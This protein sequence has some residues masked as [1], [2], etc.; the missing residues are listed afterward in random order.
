M[1]RK[2]CVVT[3]TRAEY[4]LLRWVMHGIQD[5]DLLELQLI[6]TGMHLSPEFGLTVQNIEADGFRIDRK[7]EMLLS[8]DTPVGITKSIG[9]GLIGCADALAELQPDFLLVLGDRFEIFS[10]VAAALIARIPIAHIHGGELTEG[11]F[12][13]AI[14]HS[15][16]KMSH[17]HFVANDVYRNRVIQLGEHPDSVF[18]V[19]GLG[20][21]TMSRIK[22]LKREDLEAALD[23]KFGER[24]LLVTFHPVTLENSTSST[25]IH[26]LLVSLEMLHGTHLIFTMPNADTDSRNLFDIIHSYCSSHPNAK[27]FTSLGQLLYLSCM[28]QVDGVIGNSSSGLTEAPSFNIGTVNIG[29]RQKGRL[30]ASSV[31]DAEPNTESINAALHRLFSE[32]FDNSLDSTVNPYGTPGASDLIV[33]SLEN[34]LK[35]NSLKKEFYDL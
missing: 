2:I 17:F 27:L 34:K 26:E 32:D 31:I 7:V 21:D 1:L 30:R 12:D 3:G 23:F 5:S 35:I 20:V 13:D 24:N 25:Q 9:L 19:G 4:G 16:T 8:S 15:I 28:N 22:L 14:R 10:V 29:D 33:H 11:A 18:T 6:A